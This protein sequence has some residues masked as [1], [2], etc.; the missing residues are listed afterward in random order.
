MMAQF[1]PAEVR[2]LL[3]RMVD[4]MNNNASA[5]AFVPLGPAAVT[6]M[7]GR[8]AQQ[9]RESFGAG[10]SMRL[11]RIDAAPLNGGRLPVKFVVLAKSDTRSEMPM[12]FIAL[13]DRDPQGQLKIVDL[14][15]EIP[16]RRGR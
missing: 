8:G 7:T 11:G 6:A 10:L 12:I 5:D 2:A 3:Q 15:R 9:M 1:H 16:G 13:I 4:A 14:R